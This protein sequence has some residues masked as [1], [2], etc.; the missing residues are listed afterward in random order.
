MIHCT[1]HTK[2]DMAEEDAER[3]WSINVDGTKMLYISTDYVFPGN[4]EECY[5]P[6]D[7]CDHEAN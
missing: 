1:A 6:E 5:Q 2:V 7:A 4:S 3:C